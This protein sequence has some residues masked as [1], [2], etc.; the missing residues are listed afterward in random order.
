[1]PGCCGGGGTA[2]KKTPAQV[3]RTAQIAMDVQS[4]TLI[5]YVGSNYGSQRWGGPGSTKSGRTYVFGRTERDR[6]RYVDNRDVKWMLGV[7]SDGRPVFRVYK[8]VEQKPVE[9]ETTPDAP[10]PNSLTIA[11]IKELDLSPE[12][13]ELVLKAEQN[14][15]NR[16][17]AIEF[18]ETK[19]V[20][21][22]SV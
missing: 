13:W 1:M 22:Q 21:A 11:E 17:G 14:G 20:Y 10:D 15:K 18:I 5:E 2:K 9:P 4:M 8:P 19:I 12:L 7:Q 6:V 3:A 16:A